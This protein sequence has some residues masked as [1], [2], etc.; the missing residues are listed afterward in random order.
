MPPLGCSG[1]MRPSSQLSPLHTTCLSA[2]IWHSACLRSD[3]GVQ[4]WLVCYFLL[5]VA[6]LQDMFVD[7]DLAQET[8]G[9][10]NGIRQARSC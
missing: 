6:C 8:A 7:F 4:L 1:S 10:I 3:A 5:C 2:L 9:S